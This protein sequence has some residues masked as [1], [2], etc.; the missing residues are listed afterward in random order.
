MVDRMNPQ[1]LP[2]R[3]SSGR[4]T[5][6]DTAAMRS[7]LLDAAR[8]LFAQKGYAN[9]TL[10]ELATTLGASKHTIYR[11]FSGKEPLFDAV[12]ERDIQSFRQRL[13]SVKAETPM[14]ALYRC[15]RRYF[16]YGID[17]SYAAFYLFVTAEAAISKKMR[18]KLARWSAIALEPL[19][20]MVV[21]SQASGDLA[22]GDPIHLCGI[23]VDLLDGAANRTRLNDQRGRNAKLTRVVFEER[24]MLFLNLF[25]Q[26][27]PA[28]GDGALATTVSAR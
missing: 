13:S 23:L 4:P 3:R 19:Q 8:L 6:D 21:A 14:D 20:E 28:D 11:R 24:W 9:A 10:D 12:V 27:P 18:K 25:S 22:S 2:N 1:Q 17:E 26:R 5:K 15:S 7:R 16:E